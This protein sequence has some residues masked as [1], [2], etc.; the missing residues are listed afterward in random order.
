MD[1]VERGRRLLAD[2]GAV[3]AILACAMHMTREDTVG[4]TTGILWKC[5]LLRR[6]REGE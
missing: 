6:R 2:G 4:L 1:G 3:K 5:T